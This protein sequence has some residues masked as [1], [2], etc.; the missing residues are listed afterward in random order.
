MFI[1]NRTSPGVKDA[2]TLAQ[3]GYPTGAG[4]GLF[5]AATYTC[6]HCNA[7]VV[8]E[9]KR[10][11]ARGFCLGCGQ[12]ICDGCEYIRT[13]TLTCRSMDQRITELQELDAVKQT[14]QDPSLILLEKDT[15]HG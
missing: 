5:E 2:A 11:R 9:P 13:R 10:T 1:D 8:L 3:L 4:H 12:H 14:D 15:T 6:S 7:V